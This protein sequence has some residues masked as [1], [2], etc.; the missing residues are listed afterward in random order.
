[1]NSFYGY[2]PHAPMN[3]SMNTPMNGYYP[4]SIPSGFYRPQRP[5]MGMYP[6]PNQSYY[7][8]QEYG[9][10]AYPPSPNPPIPMNKRQEENRRSSSPVDEFGRTKKYHP[11]SRENK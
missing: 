6:P 4:P 1:M 3:A 11:Y 9:Y 10:G 7:G 8:M 5:P 2:P